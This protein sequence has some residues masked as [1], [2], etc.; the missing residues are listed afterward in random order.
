[1][2]VVGDTLMLWP[3]IPVAL[4]WMHLEERK[5]VRI[6]RELDAQQLAEEQSAEARARSPPEVHQLHPHP[7][8]VG[9]VDE[10]EW[11]SAEVDGGPAGLD[12]RTTELH[13]PSRGAATSRTRKDRWVRPDWLTARRARSPKGA[14]SRNARSSMRSALGG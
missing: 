11:R 5:A 3:M 7:V 9:A 10:L 8:G 12:H 14:G 2:W 13:D 1:M 6:D 4:R